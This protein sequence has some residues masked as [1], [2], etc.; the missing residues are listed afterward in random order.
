M[1]KV[2]ANKYEGVDGFNKSIRDALN[3]PNPAAQD[4]FWHMMTDLEKRGILKEKIKAFDLEFDG[5][6]LPCVRCKFD[7]ELNT[8][9][10]TD[11]KYLE[12]KSYSNA[13]KI[14]KPQFLNYI[15][16]VD[17]L[18]QLQYI[19]NKSKLSIENAREGM[20]ELFTK[21]N[22]KQEIFNAMS[23]DLKQS[24]NLIELSDLTSV[25]I[26]QIINVIVKSL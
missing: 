21:V 22:N 10:Q 14:S 4:G 15:S 16:K 5:D 1:L 25:K 18:E 7:V 24:L 11:L 19:F 2:I 26:D 3:N 23:N 12:Y 13:S 8:N 9:N 17:K 6:D 20:K